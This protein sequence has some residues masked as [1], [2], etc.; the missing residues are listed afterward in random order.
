MR[1]IRILI[2]D[3][4]AVVRM[5]LASLF[6]AKPDFEVVGQA[7]NGEIAIRDA[8]RLSPDVVVMDLMMP[9]KDGVETT[10][11]IRASVPDAKS[12]S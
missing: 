4:H 6:S 2:V 12:L 11:A 8:K 10:H 3:D 7:K 9:G 5:G 1:K